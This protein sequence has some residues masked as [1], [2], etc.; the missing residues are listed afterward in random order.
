[1]V[2]VKLTRNL[3]IMNCDDLVGCLL[4]ASICVDTLVSISWRSVYMIMPRGGAMA[5]G[6]HAVCHSVSSRAR[7]DLLTSMAVAGDLDSSEDKT[8]HRWL[9][10]N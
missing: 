1:M 10:Y 3:R 5:Y 8:V 9:P 4:M 2:V 6:S 7:R